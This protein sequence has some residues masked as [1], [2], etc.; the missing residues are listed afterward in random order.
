MHAWESIQKAVD[1]I[2][3]KLAEEINIHGLAAD[4][5]LSPFYFQRL[6][7]RLTGKTGNEYIKLRR[8]AK[9]AD[10]LA[11]TGRRILDI[12]VDCGFAGHGSLT[13]A[14]KEAFGLTPE[15]YRA[16]PVRLDQFH[17]PELLLHYVMVDEGVPLITDSIVLE[18][19]RRTLAA[20]ETSVGRTCRM[21]TSHVPMGP[22]TGVNPAGQLIEEFKSQRLGI[23]GLADGGYDLGVAYPGDAPEGFFTYFTGALLAE[24]AE[25]PAGLASF[26][27][28]AGEY[29]VCRFE[30]E[31]LDEL[32]GSALGKATHYLYD[33]WLR[34]H[35]LGT[36]AFC[37]EKTFADIAENPVL[38]RWVQALPAAEA[39]V[40]GTP[41]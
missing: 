33:T 4:C 23:P 34:R 32:V 29:V 22:D 11:A 10:E 38:E 14:F 30:A 8:L 20:P 9:A 25:I 15:Q 41:V 3:E 7:A 6:F 13:R 27:L 12:A 16:E 31:T 28:P 24:G 35:G 21:S 5:A 1:T 26:T 37:G 36:A 40:T 18:I 17:K 39:Y 19:T 2:E